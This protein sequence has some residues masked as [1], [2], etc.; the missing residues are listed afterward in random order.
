[1]FGKFES[2]AVLDKTQEENFIAG[3]MNDF[4]KLRSKHND[5]NKEREN[6]VSAAPLR[7]NKYSAL[8]A[9]S[10]IFLE[11]SAKQL[12]S[13]I[14]LHSSQLQLWHTLQAVNRLAQNIYSC[15]LP[16][17]NESDAPLVRITQDFA[18][19]MLERKDKSWLGK[20]L[21]IALFA[22][23]KSFGNCQEKAFFGFACLLLAAQKTDIKLTSLRL[24]FFDNHFIV[25]VNEQFLMD[26]WLNIAFPLNPYDPDDTIQNVFEGF[27]ELINYF[28]I[29]TL[30]NHCFSHVVVEGSQTRRDYPSEKEF[31]TYLEFLNQQERHF[32]L[33]DENPR[34]LKREAKEIGSSDTDD[35]FLSNPQTTELI[36][37]KRERLEDARDVNQTHTSV[38]RAQNAPASPFF[39]VNNVLA[40]DSENSPPQLSSVGNKV[41]Y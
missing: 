2:P 22:K 24:A 33:P 27:G 4:G 3:F 20:I 36:R 19:D 30:K 14:P 6:S 35:S 23:R 17:D 12:I 9:S 18:D 10:V 16:S 13:D 38:S 28:S 25:V 11:R 39:F 31:K 29:D 26:P 15:D 32:A 21:E 41:F 5:A 34:K 8:D 40:A 7:P 1:M 37:S